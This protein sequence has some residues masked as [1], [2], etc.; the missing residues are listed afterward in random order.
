M[1][2]DALLTCDDIYVGKIEVISGVRPSGVSINNMSGRN[3]HGFF[4]IWDGKALLSFSDKEIRMDSGMLVYLPRKANYVMQYAKTNTVFV[5]VNFQM[6]DENGEEFALSNEISV[7]KKSD[8][9]YKIAN[10]MKNFELCSG[11]K[12]PASAFR[13]KELLYKLL[14]I[15]SGSGDFPLYE[16]SGKDSAIWEG[17]MLLHKSYLENLSIKDFAN[18]SNVS[19]SSFRSLFKA[20]FNMSPIQYRVKLRI[21]RAISLLSEGDVTVSE[22]AYACGFENIGYFYRAFKSFTG[23]TPV[24]FMKN[25]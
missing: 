12:N 3:S 11:S 17:V 19:E 18:A 1:K 2:S 7:I 25:K 20:R 13:K 8:E 6:T 14:A 21:E 16:K 5:T 15:V 23:Q 22:V 10:I 9:D 24:S 4:Y